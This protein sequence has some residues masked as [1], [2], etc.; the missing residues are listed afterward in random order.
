MKGNCLFLCG[1]Y[2]KLETLP[3]KKQTFALLVSKEKAVGEMTVR[4]N[5]I[6]DLSDLY[7]GEAKTWY[8]KIVAFN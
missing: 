6:D 4:A 5:S 3:V 8:L 2:Q 1:S 7:R